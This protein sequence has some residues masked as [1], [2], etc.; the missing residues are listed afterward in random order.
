MKK[1]PFFEVKF[2]IKDFFSKIN[3]EKAL[4]KSADEEGRRHR[5][6]MCLAIDWP[7]PD[8]LFLT[9]V[10]AGRYNLMDTSKERCT[11]STTKDGEERREV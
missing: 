10:R 8:S 4:Q 11:K 2:I 6:N 5:P 9:R 7:G 1:R 3:R